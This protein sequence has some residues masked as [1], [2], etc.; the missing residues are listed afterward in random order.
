MDISLSADMR[1]LIDRQIRNGAFANP[2]AVVLAGLK[3]LEAQE[4][5]AEELKQDVLLGIAQANQREFATT[6][7]A[8]EILGDIRANRSHNE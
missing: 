8:T 6:K 2:E 7:S 5:L 3:L 1:H 4:Q